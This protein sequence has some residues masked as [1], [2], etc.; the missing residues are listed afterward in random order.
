MDKVLG[1]ARVVT[2]N[3]IGEGGEVT[4]VGGKYKGVKE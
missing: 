3:E 2:K 1:E 4:E